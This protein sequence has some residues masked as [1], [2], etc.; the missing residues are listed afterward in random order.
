MILCDGCDLGWHLS[1]ISPPLLSIP[2]EDWYCTACKSSVLELLG[3]DEG[4]S[5]ASSST[6]SSSNP[7]TSHALCSSHQCS[8]A[9]RT[10][11]TCSLV[12]HLVPMDLATH[13]A[14]QVQSSAGAEPQEGVKGP[15][16][17]GRGGEEEDG[18]PL[19]AL[20][21]SRISSIDGESPHTRR[22]GGQRR[23][24]TGVCVVVCVCC[25]VCVCYISAAALLRVGRM[26]GSGEQRQVC[27][28]WC[29]CVMC[30]VRVV[31][32]CVYSVHLL[33]TCVCL[34]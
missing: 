26:E 20:R 18:V 5:S 30:C 23:A 29:V 7:S 2:K 34:C 13:S 27:D 25:V 10:P 33:F 32:V 4:S 1:C 15:P 14:A 22:G 6:T 8:L 9:E 11:G 31:C 24:E 28:V 3:E 16:R 17:R 21:A 19:A 12:E